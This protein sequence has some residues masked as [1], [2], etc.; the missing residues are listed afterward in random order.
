M[1]NYIK[2]FKKWQLG[3]IISQIKATTTGYTMPYVMIDIYDVFVQKNPSMPF[4][5][6]DWFEL[7]SSIYEG[8]TMAIDNGNIINLRNFGFNQS[9]INNIILTNYSEREL[10]DSYL[11]NISDYDI[12]YEIM[13]IDIMAALNYNR[14]K[15]KRLFEIYTSE[16]NPLWNVDG[17]ETETHTGKDITSHSG[18]DNIEHGG[19]DISENKG[20]DSNAHSGADITTDNNSD[21]TDVSIYPF[22]GAKQP[23][24]ESI[25]T[26]GKSTTVNHGETITTSYNSSNELKHGETINTEYGHIVDLTH[27]ETI[28]RTRGGNIG[29]TMTTDLLKEHLTFWNGFDFLNIVASDIVE[30]ISY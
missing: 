11:H 15:Y 9:L 7:V 26:Y 14:E 27:G 3:H 8:D 5:L 29:T 1:I 12:A 18:N 22:D 2:D 19:K 25:T 13:K 20:S 23:E 4:I 17:R 6:D 16:Y 24:S 21:K 10:K 28:T 30:V